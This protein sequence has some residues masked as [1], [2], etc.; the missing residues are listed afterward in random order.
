[1][2]IHNTIIISIIV[3]VGIFQIKYNIIFIIFTSII[4]SIT[5]I[6]IHSKQEGNRC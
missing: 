6:T 2:N 5:I 1:M 4:I 3:V